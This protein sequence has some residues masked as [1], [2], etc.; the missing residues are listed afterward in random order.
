MLLL[1]ELWSSQDGWQHNKET[2]LSVKHTEH[3][4]GG[5]R[6]FNELMLSVSVT[7]GIQSNKSEIKL[8][9]ATDKLPSFH[10][11]QYHL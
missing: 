9:T 2:V 10:I 1:A 7:I 6:S 4:D 8:T 5:L 3:K 11:Q